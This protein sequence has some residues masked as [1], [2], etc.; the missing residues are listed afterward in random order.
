MEERKI[1]VM[2]VGAHAGDAELMAGGCSQNT[3]SSDTK[4]ASCI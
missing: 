3:I 4:P 1:H 2:V